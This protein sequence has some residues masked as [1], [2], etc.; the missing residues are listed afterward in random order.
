MKRFHLYAKRLW[1]NE[2]VTSLLAESKEHAQ[3]QIINGGLMIG[4][5][6]FNEK[7]F[8]SESPDMDTIGQTEPY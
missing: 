8:V 2:H 4:Q 7:Y 3:E 5:E 1:G 6:P